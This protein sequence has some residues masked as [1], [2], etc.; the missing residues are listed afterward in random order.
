MFRFNPFLILLICHCFSFPLSLSLISNPI[1]TVISSISTCTSIFVSVSAASASPS[2]STSSP[3]CSHG[4]LNSSYPACNIRDNCY[5]STTNAVCSATGQ[6]STTGV[7]A[8]TISG[9]ASNATFEYLYGV[10]APNYYPNTTSMILYLIDFDVGVLSELNIITEQ[11]TIL[12]SD[13]QLHEAASLVGFNPITNLNPLYPNHLLIPSANSAILSVSLDNPVTVSVICGALTAL[14]SSGHMDG[15][16]SGGARFGY[17]ASIAI[18]STGRYCLIA[19]SSANTLRL[20]NLTSLPHYVYTVAGV[21]GTAG[22][23]DSLVGGLFATFFRPYA[24]RFDR[25]NPDSIAY[26]SDSLNAEV[27]KL[28]FV[29]NTSGLYVTSVTR[30]AGSYSVVVDSPSSTALTTTFNIVRDCLED[31]LGYYMYCA[32]NYA[33]L[34]FDMRNTSHPSK[35]ITNVLNGPGVGDSANG[36]NSS[37]GFNGIGQLAMMKDPTTHR[38]ILFVADGDNNKVR[39]VVISPT[40]PSTPIITSITLISSTPSASVQLDFSLS[41]DGGDALTSCTAIASPYA[42]ISTTNT[43]TTTTVRTATSGGS[44]ISS[45]GI[46]ITGSI[47]FSSLSPTF[48]NFSMS[49]SN[50][51]SS[52]QSSSPFPFVVSCPHGYLNP[53]TCNIHDECYWSKT[54]A[55]CSVT[56]NPNI[57]G[58]SAPTTVT[59]SA[60]SN[61]TFGRVYGMIAPNYYPNTTNMMLYVLDYTFG[62]LSQLDIIQKTVTILST[63]PQLVGARNIAAFNPLTNRNPNYPNHLLINK[64]ASAI[65]SFALNGSATLSIICGNGT[66][67]DGD[68]SCGASGSGR[69]NAPFGI[70]IHSSGAFAFFAEYNLHQIRCLNLTTLPHTVYTIAGVNGVTGHADSLVSGLTATFYYPVSI[71]FDVKN[72]DHIVYVVDD[73]NYE[74]RKLTYLTNSTG[75]Y[76]TAVETWA[77]NY[78]YPLDQPAATALA[79]LLYFPLQ[80]IMDYFGDC[81]YCGTADAIFRFDMNN[82][83]HPSQLVTNVG[84]MSHY[85]DNPNGFDPSVGFYAIFGMSL[86]KDPITHRLILFVADSAHY[87]IRSVVIP[88]TPPS[89]PTIISVLPLSSSS[90]RLAFTI[91][92]DGGDGL[93]ACSAIASSVPVSSNITAVGF[94]INSISTNSAIPNTS[95]IP[96]VYNANTG[97]INASMFITQL[98][99]AYSYTFSLACNNSIG[100]SAPSS[101]SSPFLLPSCSHG[102]INYPACNVHDECYWSTTNAVCSATGK[103]STRGYYAPTVSGPASTATFKTISAMIAPNYYPNTTDMILYAIDYNSGIL[104]RLDI[105]QQQ[106]TV[107]STDPKL[108]TALGMAAFNPLTNTNPHYPNHFLITT[109]NN[110]VILSFALDGSNTLNTICGN[111]IAGAGDG[112][113]GAGGLGQFDKP[114]AIQIHS[115]GAFAFVTDSGTSQIRCLNLS[116]LPHTVYTIAGVYDEFYGHADSLVGGLSATFNQ[117]QSIVFDVMDP[118]HIAYVADY[119]NSEVRKLTYFTNSTGYYVTAVETWAGSFD[120]SAD[121]PAST[122]LAT[123]FQYIWDCIMDCFGDY[124][125]CG[126]NDAIFRFDMKNASH[127]SQVL[128][129]TA[130]TGQYADNPNGLDPSVGFNGANGLSLMKDPITHR[131]I[132]FVADANNY[133]IRSVVIPPTPPSTPAITSVLPLSSASVSVEF[134]VADDGGDALTSCSAIA[135]SS[136]FDLITTMP[137]NETDRYTLPFTNFL[138]FTGL[139]NEISYN[140]TVSCNNSIGLSQSTIFSVIAQ[141]PVSNASL[142]VSNTSL[143]VSNASLPVIF[144]SPQLRSFQPSAIFSS[145]NQQPTNNAVRITL[146]GTNLFP[147]ATQVTVNGQQVQVEAVS[148]ISDGSTIIIVINPAESSSFEP[149]TYAEISLTNPN[150]PSVLCAGSST[151]QSLLASTDITSCPPFYSSLY[152][153]PA[154][155]IPN[156]FCPIGVNSSSSCSVC[157]ANSVCPGGNRVQPTAGYYTPDETSGAV[158]Q[159]DDPTGERCVGLASQPNGNGNGGGG[160]VS[161]E[162]ARQGCGVGYIGTM[163]SECSDGYY[164]DGFVCLS[165]SGDNSAS[166]L[167]ISLLTFFFF[168]MP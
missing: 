164:S 121:Q 99:P 77:G 2:T 5:W 27:R 168:A 112:S 97:A 81:M 60:T 34:Q 13:I 145:G 166:P 101:P 74:V 18:H 11:V 130:K 102:Y 152:I 49:C 160:L 147:S 111:G 98:L 123:R 119:G 56:G 42:I 91:A 157:P 159:C 28:T 58:V 66:A 62:I 142:P 25:L 24:I 46:I 12:S 140:L 57:I 143:P 104:S 103:T 80:C 154:I 64:D 129:S 48:Y 105:I 71:V 153:S 73:N 163:C 94:V 93:I 76:V 70:Q 84:D 150:S 107:L 128:T 78:L 165:C 127:P 45:G 108:V 36:M 161:I 4:F 67:G 72:P 88:P 113:C 92:N 126:S 53:P 52:S 158:Y 162:S 109:Y 122:A 89:A 68:G 39:S 86:M 96:V 151:S 133:K 156:S 26:V 144:A 1:D 141:L 138:L 3:S 125:Y 132:L 31:D 41:S 139:S 149:D 14:G 32:S 38:L 83:S 30:W 69:V 137:I 90:V 155:I 79:T 120:Q 134:T 136:A 61:A 135:I 8:S 17:P 22:H 43:F 16:C 59:D 82:S 148:G 40:A 131:L 15:S 55:V 110:H 114:H 21:A 10:F 95:S 20:L 6:P 54:N 7:F 47:Y 65:L 106:V 44:S 85:A 167:L 29:T 117:L 19:D 124:M 23:A 87:K 63:D 35:A 37:V 118:D 75:I 100:T 146:V 116:S 51:I 50:N 9:P 33:I 115:S